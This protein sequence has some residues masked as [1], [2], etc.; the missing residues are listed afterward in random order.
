M[1]IEVLQAPLFRHFVIFLALAGLMV[2]CIDKSK[3]N[4]RTR[5]AL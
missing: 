1:I 3:Q 2:Y 4:K 5:H